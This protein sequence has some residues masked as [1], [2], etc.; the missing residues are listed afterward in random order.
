MNPANRM[1][2]SYLNG[3]VHELAK[4]LRP[5]KEMIIKLVQW[6]H[7]PSLREGILILRGVYWAIRYYWSTRG[8]P[9]FIVKLWLWILDIFFRRLYS[10]NQNPI[11]RSSNHPSALSE[12]QNIGWF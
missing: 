1:N 4:R 11:Y 9:V 7:F 5:T 8:G 2:P 3:P 12:K 6:D 10:F